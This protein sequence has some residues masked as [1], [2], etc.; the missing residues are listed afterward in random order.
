ME[1][2]DCIRQIKALENQS[3]ERYDSVKR[4][5]EQTMPRQEYGSRAT[6]LYAHKSRHQLIGEQAS[7]DEWVEQGRYS[8][9]EMSDL[10]WP[11]MEIRCVDPKEIMSLAKSAG[12]RL[13]QVDLLQDWRFEADSAYYDG[14]RVI[15]DEKVSEDKCI[16]AAYFELLREQETDETELP[17]KYLRGCIAH[18]DLSRLIS[19][20]N[21]TLLSEPI[22]D[23]G[24]INQLYA[25]KLE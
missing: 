5:L 15:N 14:A 2:I 17:N 7:K 12:G 6:S 16:K 8:L 9:R 24:R 1:K 22:D 18:K 20:G 23:Q 11:N 21:A 4:E 19:T 3:N 10:L 13:L 25:L